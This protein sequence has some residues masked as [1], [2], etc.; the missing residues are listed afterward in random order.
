MHQFEYVH[1]FEKG[2]IYVYAYVFFYIC[3]YIGFGDE[4]LIKF[5]QT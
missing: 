2:F 1:Q 3:V 5:S 4:A